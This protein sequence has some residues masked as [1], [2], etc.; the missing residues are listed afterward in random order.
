MVCEHLDNNI[1]GIDFINDLGM[2]YDA[3]AQHVFSILEAKQTLIA[4]GE[5]SIGPF[6]TE[7]IT[8]R[9]T[10]HINPFATHVA[11]VMSPQLRHL[12][13]GPALVE[14]NNNKICQL[15]ITNVAPY[16]INITRKKFIGGLHQWISMD[17]P[18]PL[19]PQLMEK[20]ISKLVTKM[21]KLLRDP[22]KSQKPLNDAEI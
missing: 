1:L 12:L 4:T 5:I 2:S 11:T 16:E 7:V 17:P 18:Q 13:G 10:G 15:A 14:F 8:A 3:S 6:S 20:L 19:S 22:A 9:Y 21:P